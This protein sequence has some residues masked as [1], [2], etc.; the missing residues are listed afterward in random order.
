MPTYNYKCS[1]CAKEKTEY[2]AIKTSIPGPICDV[3]RVEMKKIPGAPMP[4]IIHEKTGVRG[5]NVRRDVTEQLKKRAHEHFSK[6]E[7]ADLIEEHG[8]KHAKDFGWVDRASGKKKKLIDE[9]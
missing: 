9:K 4:T 6:Y 3:C 8:I 5:K 1:S 7:S 2:R